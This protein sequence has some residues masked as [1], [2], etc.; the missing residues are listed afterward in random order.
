MACTSTGAA[1]GRGRMG[2]LLVDATNKFNEGNQ[3]A[4]FWMLHDEWPSGA[5]FVFNF[6]QHWA[7]LV[8]CGENGHALFIFSKEGIIQGDPLLWS[9]MAS[10]SSLLS[11]N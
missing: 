6:Y 2:F 5:W 9:H 10:S 7:I 11:A 4:M 8:V 1:L 3:I